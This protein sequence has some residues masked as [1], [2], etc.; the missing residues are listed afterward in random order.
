MELTSAAKECPKGRRKIAVK[1]VDIFGNDTTKVI[2][3]K[4]LMALDPNFP[5]SPY[6]IL[7]P[8]VRWFPGD[9]LFREVG[10]QKL[11]PPL[12]DN[13]RQRVKSWRD[14]GYED[15]SATS[16]TLLNWWFQREHLVPKADGSTLNFRYYF[17]SAKRSR[18]SCTSTTC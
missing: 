8:A 14:K 5:A 9:D 13:I 2:E 6:E 15:A 18:R 17:A 4:C 1:V 7:D 16:K 12:V 3:V 10:R 11:L